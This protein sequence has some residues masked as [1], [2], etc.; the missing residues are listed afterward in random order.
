MWQFNENKI[1]NVIEKELLGREG[2]PTEEDI[3][4]VTFQQLK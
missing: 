3:K 2:L 1:H 4:A